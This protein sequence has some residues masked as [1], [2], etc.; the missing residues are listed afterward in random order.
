MRLIRF[1]TLGCV[2]AAVAACSDSTTVTTP[3]L[4]ALAG[5]RY[6]NAVADTGA[7]DIRMIDQVEWSAVANN[8]NFRA[9]TESQPTE[10]KTRKIRVFNFIGATGSTGNIG[11]VQTVLADTTV[12]F[13]A[14]GRYT[15]VL[16]GSARAKTVK[17][18][19]LTDDAPP[20]SSTQIAVRAVNAST[21]AINGYITTTPTD[22]ITGTPAA[23]NLAPYAA[24]AY[25]TRAPGNV[26][27]RVTDVGSTTANASVAGPTAPVGP[28]GSIPAAGVNTGT[29][30]FSAF[31]FP[32]GVAGSP[33]NAVTAPTI[34]W[35][36]DRQP[37]S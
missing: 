34:V 31:Y 7:V 15:L 22:P 14:N 19:I 21:G 11:V 32:R 26:A 9:G 35:F 13:A 8:L 28:T 37:T 5:V 23:S 27:L 12:T 17:F 25:V 29:S 18:V 30:A 4:P 2:L 20:L 10:A 36:V 16:T 24:S 33:Q 6:I 1:V 3:T